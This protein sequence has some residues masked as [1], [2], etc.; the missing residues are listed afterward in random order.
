MRTQVWGIVAALA[1]VG[2]CEPARQH[3]LVPAFGEAILDDGAVVFFDIGQS[4]PT[5][6]S[7]RQLMRMMPQIR[8]A[9]TTMPEG[10]RRLCI[11]GHTDGTGAEAANRVL[12]LLRAQTVAERMIDLG[13]P[14][15]DLVVRGFGNSRPFIARRNS[16]PEAHNRV[17]L[18]A[19]GERCAN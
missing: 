5:P 12:S 18:I 10:Q 2:G 8:S 15:S 3:V 4:S 13:I 6:E 17:V 7:E 1:L 11:A 9:L 19:R 14:L 16:A